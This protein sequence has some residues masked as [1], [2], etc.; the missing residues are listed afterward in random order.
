MI[1]WQFNKKEEKKREKK[2]LETTTDLSPKPDQLVYSRNDCGDE[3]GSDYNDDRNV[4][5]VI[6][7]NI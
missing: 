2:A 7:G 1:Y 3:C 6:N 4:D 5:G